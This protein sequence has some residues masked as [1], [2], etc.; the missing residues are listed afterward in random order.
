MSDMSA[1]SRSRP[2]LGLRRVRMRSDLAKRWIWAADGT[3]DRGVSIDIVS[4]NAPL[5]APL[6]E[7]PPCR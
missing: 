7:K 1:F 6:K 2:D 5:D 3:T 4:Q